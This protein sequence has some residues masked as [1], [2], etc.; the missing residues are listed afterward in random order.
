MTTI[1]TDPSHPQTVAKRDFKAAFFGDRERIDQV[2]GKERRAQLAKLVDLHPDVINLENLPQHLSQLQEMEVIFSTWNMPLL[3]SEQL[4]QLPSLRAVFY[5][6]GSVRYFAT[7]LLD[8]GITV[9]SAWQANAIPVAEF[10]L[11]QIILA[12]KGY[13]PNIRDYNSPRRSGNY[14]ETVALLGAGAIGGKLIELLRHITLRVIVFDPFLSAETAE[15]LG[16][17]KV[18][19]NECFERGLV[20]SNHLAGVPETA[21]LLTGSLFD[22]MRENATFINTARGATVDAEPAMIQVLQR[23]PDLTALLDVTWPEPPVAG[24]PLYTLPNVHLTKHIAGSF[25]DEFLRMA[26]F[27]LEEFLSWQHGKALRFAISRSML[28]KMA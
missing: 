4:D 6:G 10:T 16:V 28:D 3:T 27:C 12:M 21:N 7:P 1:T 26:D 24:S 8:R 25:G 20:V 17:E 22:R 23:Q 13:F 15:E 11:S 9:V 14:G 5:A 18:T 2:Y 19:I